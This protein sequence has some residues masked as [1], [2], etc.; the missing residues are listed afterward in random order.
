MAIEIDEQVHAQRAPEAREREVRELLNRFPAKL[1]M[2]TPEEAR[3]PQQKELLAL[4]DALLAELEH[5][6][7]YIIGV[8]MLVRAQ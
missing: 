3:T 1:A 8:P 6:D 4:S 5:A 2:G 7:E